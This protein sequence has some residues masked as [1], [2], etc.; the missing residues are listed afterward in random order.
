[1]HNY[2]PRPMTIEEFV[3]LLMEEL[4]ERKEIKE[5]ETQIIRYDFANKK[6]L[7]PKD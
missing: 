1:M 2:P 4:A 5:Q 6:I 3:D 7:S